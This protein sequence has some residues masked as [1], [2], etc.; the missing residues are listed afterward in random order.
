MS[1][2]ETA[3]M[4]ILFP[5]GNMPSELTPIAEATFALV[6]GVLDGAVVIQGPYIDK[7]AAERVRA[8]LAGCGC[9][10]VGDIATLGCTGIVH[11][12]Y[13]QADAQFVREKVAGS[14]VGLTCF[15]PPDRYCLVHETVG[16]LQEGQAA[17]YDSTSIS[18]ELTAAE[19]AKFAFVEHARRVVGPTSAARMAAVRDLLGGR[20]GI[21]D[22]TRDDLRR[23]LV[24][25]DASD[26]IIDTD[27]E[28]ET[29]AATD[30]RAEPV[31]AESSDTDRRAA[32]VAAPPVS[33]ASPSPSEAYAVEVFLKQ[34]AAGL[35]AGLTPQV[36]EAQ[37]AEVAGV[38]DG[39]RRK[40]L[41]LV[42][43]ATAQE[44]AW[45]CTIHPTTEWSCRF[46]AA[47]EIVAGSYVPGYV[48]AIDPTASEAFP[49]SAVAS[50]EIAER[51]S[52]HAAADVN[53]VGLF[54][55]VA[56][57]RRHLARD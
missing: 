13:T 12:G 2:I 31:P 45:E 49:A 4:E 23:L 21:P 48:M 54:V 15:V 56:R 11:H 57:W 32:A 26:T 14:G 38:P 24:R 37:F 30:V 17:R 41:A 50:T 44:P 46:C 36:L 16:G 28:A 33:A 39:V 29:E 40:V 53:D 22:D 3:Q 10:T 6:P 1:E 18:R 43:L 25:D 52:A 9:K 55:E 8:I 42:Q 51:V 19:R 7:P 27:A 47:A 5:D 20:K 34:I 35:A